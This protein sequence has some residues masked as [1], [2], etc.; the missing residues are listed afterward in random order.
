MCLQ[1][2]TGQI[3]FPNALITERML[4]IFSYTCWTLIVRPAW[5]RGAA[6][7]IDAASI[8]L[9]VRRSRNPPSQPTR[10]GFLRDINTALIITR[11]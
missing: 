4:R 10:N 5:S 2:V 3:L 1:F 9:S 8:V 6:G 7:N 11:R